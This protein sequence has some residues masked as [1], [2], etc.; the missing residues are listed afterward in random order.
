V[1]REEYGGR[2]LSGEARFTRRYPTLVRGTALAGLAGVAIVGLVG[3]LAAIGKV[4]VLTA[5]VVVG[6]LVAGVLVMLEYT[7]QSIRVATDVGEMSEAELL[8][9]LA[10]DGAGAVLVARSLPGASQASPASGGAGTTDDE[11]AGPAEEPAAE[12]PDDPEETA[13][14]GEP[15][16]DDDH[17]GPEDPEDPDDERDDHDGPEDPEDPD[18]ERGESG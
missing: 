17:D 1:S 14:D 8:R 3:W 11:A 13:P 10:D 6:V 2:G 15:G 5:W 4:V 18:D 12:T 9:P 7:R 16:G